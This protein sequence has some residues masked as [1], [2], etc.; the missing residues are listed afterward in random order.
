MTQQAFLARCK[1]L[2]EVWQRVPNGYLRALLEKAGCPRA[3]VKDLGTIKLLQALTNI[4]QQ[5]NAHEEAVGAF[6]SLRERDGWNDR[7]DA[8][9]P[10]FLNN[11]LRIADAHESVNQCLETLRTMGFDTAH[12]NDGYGLAFDFVMDG[13]VGAL[14]V[15][16]TAARRLLEH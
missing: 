11:D 14:N 4:V 13:V 2:H 7:N 12:V 8:M 10:L 3:A 6:S 1:S 16:N 5:L 9:A 15:C